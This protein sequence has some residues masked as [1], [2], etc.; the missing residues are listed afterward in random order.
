LCSR[1]ELSVEPDAH[2]S[3]VTPIDPPAD[4]PTH[5]DREEVLADGTRIRIRPIV[6]ADIERLR[7]AF[8]VGDPESIRRRFF[9]GAPPTGEVYLRYLVE[10]DYHRRLALV[11]MDMEGN[12]LGVARYEGVQAFPL[13][14]IAI[15]VTPEWRHRGVALMLVEALELPAIDAGFERFEALYLPDNRAIADLLEGLGYGDLKL[16]DGFVSV[17]KHLS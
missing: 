8:A 4:Y 6:P 17:T 11:A 1:G 14:E 2:L 5:L 13:A 9:T 7:H 12:S 3:P 15:V 16:N 10:I